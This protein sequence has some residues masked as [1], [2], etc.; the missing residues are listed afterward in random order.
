MSVCDG[1]SFFGFSHQT[2]TRNG[3]KFNPAR[4]TL[5]HLSER[6]QHILSMGDFSLGQ[7]EFCGRLKSSLLLFLSCRML[8]CTKLKRNNIDMSALCK[9]IK[10]GVM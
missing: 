7:S 10:N 3:T 6:E 9:A 2:E 1:T 8:K 5:A 4:I